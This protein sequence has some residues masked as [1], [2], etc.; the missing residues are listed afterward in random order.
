MQ[1]DHPHIIKLYAVYEDAKYF[2][3]VMELCEGGELFDRIVEKLYFS[4]QE[5][6]FHFKNMLSA[7]NHLHT[8]DIV[9]RDMKPENFL[10]LSKKPDAEIKLI[11][12]GLSR[13]FEKQ[14]DLSSM[15]GTPYY[16]APEVL[17][18]SYG[19][20]C[21]IWGLGVVLYTMLSGTLPFGGG[22]NAEIF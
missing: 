22:S 7:L 17:G 8:N 19:K 4:E 10:F 1:V 2:H 18:G 15:V 16:V 14:V 13:K 9:H 21:D 5:A 11:D 3:I 6:A 20:E 12:F